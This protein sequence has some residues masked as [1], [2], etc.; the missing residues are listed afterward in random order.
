MKIKLTEKEKRAFWQ[1]VASVRAFRE[2]GVVP[3]DAEIYILNED[4]GNARDTFRQ[5]KRH[6]K[7]RD[8]RIRFQ[9]KFSTLVRSIMLRKGFDPKTY[10]SDK[11]KSFDFDGAAD[12]VEKTLLDE[13]GI[14]SCNSY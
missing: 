14:T 11:L 8:N 6:M 7:H 9:E 5:A 10:D 4:Q 13:Y 2:H 12:A 3:P 1:E